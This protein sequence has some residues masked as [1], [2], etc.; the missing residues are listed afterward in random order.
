LAA[1]NEGGMF[2]NG[3]GID[4]PNKLRDMNEGPP[5]RIINKCNY[6]LRAVTNAT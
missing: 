2:S 1:P 4:F 3:G 6:V 5:T